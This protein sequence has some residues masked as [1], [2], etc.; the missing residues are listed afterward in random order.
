MMDNF[1]N[2]PYAKNAMIDTAERV[3]QQVRHH[4]RRSATT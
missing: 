4:P 1:G 3:A 2:D